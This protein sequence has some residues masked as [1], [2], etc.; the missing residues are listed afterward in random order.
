ML[1]IRLQRNAGS[2]HCAIELA[3]GRFGEIDLSK[4]TASSD[5]L[6][7]FSGLALVSKSVRVRLLRQ[8]TLVKM[9]AGDV[10][11]SSGSEPTHYIILVGGSV[12][13]QEIATDGTASVLYYIRAGGACSQTTHCLLENAPYQAEG[14]VERESLIVKVPRELFDH[15]MS[16]SAE[17]EEFVLGAICDAGDNENNSNERLVST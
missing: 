13:V 15:L 3:Y 11:F 4:L 14:I 2:I 16:T 9:T 8:S 17:F 1:P 12:R 5:W 6:E 7:A 10:V